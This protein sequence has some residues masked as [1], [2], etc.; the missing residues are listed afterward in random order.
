MCTQ[1]EGERHLRAGT[2]QLS[3]QGRRI[4]TEPP[5]SSESICPIDIDIGVT[6]CTRRI[7][8]STFA[9]RR[10]LA[11]NLCSDSE[12]EPLASFFFCGIR[13]LF[14]AARRMRA[15]INERI[16]QKCGSKVV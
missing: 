15:N 3:L 14:L 16:H 9:R 13:S 1:W 12:L 4:N 11:D 7:L 8:A 5:T 10:V 2:G 6:G